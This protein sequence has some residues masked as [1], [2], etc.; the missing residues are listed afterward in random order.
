MCGAPPSFNAHC[1][2]TLEMQSDSQPA[3]QLCVKL[4]LPKEAGRRV[5][6]LEPRTD[7]WTSHTTAH[8]QETW[9]L[10]RD[11]PAAREEARH[12]ETQAE[13]SMACLEQPG[14]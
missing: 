9:H 13:D 12:T 7:S 8:V 5:E 4:L 10:G 6:A 11:R 3:R 1:S 2:Q 14:R